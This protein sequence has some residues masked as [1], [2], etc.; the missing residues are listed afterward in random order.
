MNI[1]VVCQ[2][3]LNSTRL[4]RKVLLPLSGKP[5]IARFMDRVLCS[6]LAT[7]VVVATTTDSVDDELA[8]D[9]SARGYEVFRGH[10]T[11][12]L[13]R[14]YM[15]GKAYGA[16][17][18]VKIPSDCPLIDPL[19]I[20]RVLTAFLSKSND[21]DFVSNLHPASYPDGNDVEVMTMSILEK[22][23]QSATQPYEREHSTPWLW[24]GN[25]DVRCMNVLWDNHVDHSMT[26]RWTIDY[27]EDYLFINAVY[28][29]LLPRNPQFHLEDVLSLLQE[30]PE[31]AAVNAHL[32]G[33]NWYRDHLGELRT[34]TTNDT[35]S[36]PAPS[37]QHESN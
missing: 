27:P 1:V 31:I 4:P 5:L 8:N 25:P 9:C 22:A 6:R 3:R 33:V 7:T 10:P 26:H 34:I 30:R 18:V 35:R 28:D 2:A 32:A 12:L 15:A 19:I 20:D 14:H 16:D 36:F 24:D 11:D 17:V 37:I 21:V 29:A 13:D 23:W